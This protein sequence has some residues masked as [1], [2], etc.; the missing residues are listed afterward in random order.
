MKRMICALLALLLTAP[1]CAETIMPD[2]I[3]C[4]WYE[5]FVYSYQDSNGDRIGD[6]QG[7]ISRLD[8]VKD[9]GFTGI[10]LM[11]IMPSP[12][13]HKYDVTDYMDID[14]QYGTLD[15]F[16]KLVKE[17]HARGIKLII[18]MPLNHSSLQHPWFI[19]AAKAFGRA[20]R[21]TSMSATTTSGRKAA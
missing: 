19:E 14:P 8:Y 7:L 18:D 5:I 6:I 16:R 20:I 3:Y 21:I 2:D 1:A 11:P 13:Y 17:C 15:D 4:N 10:W 9:M 12:S